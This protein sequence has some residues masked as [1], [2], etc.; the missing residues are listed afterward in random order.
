[1][2]S[3]PE[4]MKSSNHSPGPGSRAFLQGSQLSK[5]VVAFLLVGLGGG[6]A[7]FFLDGA[8]D[9]RTT[10]VFQLETP[11]G[12]LDP[13]VQYD[14]YSWA[15]VSKI[16]SGLVKLDPETSEIREDLASYEI[17]TPARDYRFHIRPGVRFHN[18]R[19]VEAEDFRFA[20][21][22]LLSPELAARYAWILRP[23]DGAEEFISGNSKSITGIKIEDRYALTLELTRPY[24]PFLHHLAMPNAAVVPRESVGSDHRIADE[25]LSGTGPFEV[26]SIDLEEGKVLLRAF[27]DYYF[28]KP[29]I[30]RLEFRVMTDPNIALE[31]YWLNEVDLLT[32]IPSAFLGPFKNELGSDLHEWPGL[33]LTYLVV[34]RDRDRGDT[35]RRAVAQAIQ[36]SSV[37]ADLP[38]G[39]CYPA[40]GILPPGIG[41]YDPEN[42]GFLFDPELARSLLADAGYPAG[43]GGLTL[44]AVDNP[45]NRTIAHNIAAQ[46]AKVGIEVE[47]QPTENLR[48]F[49]EAISSEAGPDLFVL[50]WTADYPDAFSFLFPLLHSS[51]S[52]NYYHARYSNSEFDELLARALEEIDSDKRASY[53][54]KAEKLALQSAP[55]VPL[56]Y[57]TNAVAVRRGWT[58]PARS[59][60]G[61]HAIPLEKI[62]WEGE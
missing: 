16:F 54:R 12:S 37:C 9:T 3:L 31:K 19:E 60:L 7:T 58:K 26:E 25:Q 42:L 8:G 34:N 5:L 10:F 62:R 11:W 40:T 46:L 15:I 33:S 4:R 1:M 45:R 39:S 50:G 57:R 13:A 61:W 53:Y 56:F 20:F 48:D 6:A 49:L 47:Y 24:A 38:P 36:P 43:L 44:M 21:E 32:T 55:L 14:S 18:G 23:L 52:E 22:R 51:E 29:A 30:E 2:T 35:L 41:G 27:G 28:G 59:P 17:L